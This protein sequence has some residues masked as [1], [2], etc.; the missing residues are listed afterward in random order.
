M[1]DTAGS[2]ATDPPGRSGPAPAGR[3]LVI[4]EALVDVVRRLDGSTQ[5]HP[6]GSP[7][8]VALGLGR[9]DRPV[10]LLTWIGTDERGRTVREHLERSAVRLTPGSDGAD[11]TSVATATLDASGAATYTF[12]LDWQVPAEAVPDLTDV[13]VVHT[14]TIGAARAPGGPAVLRILAESRLDAT[15]TYDPN[16]RPDLL[17]D[18][19]EARDLVERLVALADVVKVSDEDLAWLEPGARPHDVAVRWATRGPALVVVT[20]GGEGAL[21][22]TAGG[23]EVDVPAPRVDVADTVGAGD[24]FMAGLVD[25][26]WSAGLLGAMH[27]IALGGVGAEVLVPVLERCARIA[28]V[29]VSRP[30]AD[31]PRA[32][33]VDGGAPAPA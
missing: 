33:E 16:I 23:V 12:D 5:E 27:R 8:N 20:R 31:P 2:V 26:L 14:S 6:G 9:L 21:A 17:G 18:H 25:G 19:D 11:H 13:V 7:A 28:A 30:G 10:D 15:I 29:T 32:A 24:S 22:V 3:A 4:G 1:T